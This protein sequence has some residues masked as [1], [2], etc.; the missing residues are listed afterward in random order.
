MFVGCL[1]VYAREKM[2]REGE[3]RKEE[4]GGERE[5]GREREREREGGR[6]RKRESDRKKSERNCVG[7]RRVREVEKGD[8]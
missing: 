6:E 2:W 7:V 8:K 3:G 4:R 5:R 1:G